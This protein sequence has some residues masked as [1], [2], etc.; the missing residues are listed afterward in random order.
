M[1]GSQGNDTFVWNP[2]DGNDSIE[3]QAGVDNLLFNGANIRRDG[4]RVSER[5]TGALHPGHRW[6]HDWT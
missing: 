2:G 6:H 5:L 4:R 3:G 1:I